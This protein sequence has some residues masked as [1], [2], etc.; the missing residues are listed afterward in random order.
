MDDILY[1]IRSLAKRLQC[2]CATAYKLVRTN[3]IRGARVGSRY[4]IT[5]SVVDEFLRGGGN[6]G[7]EKKTEERKAA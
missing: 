1:D 4:R 5:E 7:T 3:K 2:S 6:G